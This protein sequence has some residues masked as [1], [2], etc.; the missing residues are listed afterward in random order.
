MLEFWSWKNKMLT[1]Y[2]K[3]E[4]MLALVKIFHHY[5]HKFHFGQFFS[6][7]PKLQK[8]FNL[9]F[10]SKFNQGF[11]NHSYVHCAVLKVLQVFV[12]KGAHEA[13][14]KQ[15]LFQNVEKQHEMHQ[16]NLLN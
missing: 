3:V 6:S 14:D 10:R 2:V 16:A 13:E 8:D 5:Q 12:V 4:E 15:F 11:T 7:L 1:K 9:K